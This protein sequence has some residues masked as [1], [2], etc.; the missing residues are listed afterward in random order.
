MDRT[1]KLVSEHLAHRGYKYVVYEPDG[2]IPPDFL[3]DGSIAIE[4]RRLNQNHFDGQDAKGP[5]GRPT[6]PMP[7]RL[8]LLHPE[9]ERAPVGAEG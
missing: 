8:K 9:V 1:E 4:V 5:G 2:N 3:V 7:G 6:S